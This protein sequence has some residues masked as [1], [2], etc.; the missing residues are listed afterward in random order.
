MAVSW[1]HGDPKKDS[2]AVAFLD[3]EGRL[4]EH[5][6]FDN[7]QEQQMQNEFH[8]ILKRREPDLV[9]I[10]GFSAQT[11]RLYDQIRVIARDPG[12]LASI[13]EDDQMRERGE[14]EPIS[15]PVRYIIDEVARLFQHSKRAEDEFGALPVLTRY[16]IGLA[17]Y[18]QSPLNEYAALGADMIAV[19]FDDE[20][21]HLVWAASLL[22][23]AAR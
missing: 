13:S 16:C 8:N 2:I 17:R 14:D 11:H 12:Y 5:A 18:A 19:T 1:G 21:Q 22:W 7:L 10:G 4:R 9:V 15:V 20:G 6:M 3:D 23:F